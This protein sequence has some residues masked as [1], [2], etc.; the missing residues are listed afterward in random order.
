MSIQTSGL[1]LRAG[2]TAYHGVN[3]CFPASLP[4][5]QAKNV[6]QITKGIYFLLVVN[7]ESTKTQSRK[8]THKN[9]GGFS[10]GFGHLQVMGKEHP[11]FM[12]S[13]KIKLMFKKKHL[14]RTSHIIAK[15]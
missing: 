7:L 11:G 1:H 9:L 2:L 14:I 5:H 13:L 8:L 3:A 12:A 6:P 4:L 15:C 10:T